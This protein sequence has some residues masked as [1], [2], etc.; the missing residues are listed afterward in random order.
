MISTKA[1]TTGFAFGASVD[2]NKFQVRYG[3]SYYHITGAYNE[4]AINFKLNKLVHLGHPGDKLKWNS[5][6]PDWD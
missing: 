4:L 3:R 6:Y 5:E 1:G 2:L